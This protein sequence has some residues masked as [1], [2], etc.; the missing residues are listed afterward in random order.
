MTNLI[1]IKEITKMERLPKVYEM[2]DCDWWADFSLEEARKNYSDFIEIEDDESE[3]VE[4]TIEE[5]Q[6]LTYAKDCDYPDSKVFTI[7]FKQQ[8]EHMIK[9]GEKF[10]CFFASTEY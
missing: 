7:T 9:K 3:P 2:N 10:P 5:M 6:E 1:E 4:L 8:L